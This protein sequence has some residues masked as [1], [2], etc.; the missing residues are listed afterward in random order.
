MNRRAVQLPQGEPDNHSVSGEESKG[1]AKKR[2]W[3]SLTYS[4]YSI[5]ADRGLR[6]VQTVESGESKQ[7]VTDYLELDLAFWVVDWKH[8]RSGSPLGNNADWKGYKDTKSRYVMQVESIDDSGSSSLDSLVST[9]DSR[10]RTIPSI[11][12]CSP[13]RMAHE[14]GQPHG[15]DQRRDHIQ[16][17]SVGRREAAAS[18]M[19]AKL[20]NLEY[21]DLFWLLLG[22]VMGQ[23]LVRAITCH[24]TQRP[25]FR[26]TALVN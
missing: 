17:R 4:W 8:L 20:K 12:R 16:E 3:E 18:L 9:L 14:Q 13:L 11:R 7:Y 21:R 24:F 5:P 23:H 15:Q 26:R 22:S 25:S 19:W 2:R 6:V 10:G 1:T